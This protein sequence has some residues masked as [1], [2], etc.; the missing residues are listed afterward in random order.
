MDGDSAYISLWIPTIRPQDWL[1][2][3]HAH[4][5][6]WYSYMSLYHFKPM[7]NGTEGRQVSGQQNRVF[8]F[9][10]VCTVC[11][12]HTNENTCMFHVFNNGHIKFLVSFAQYH[13]ITH[14]LY[15]GWS[16]WHGNTPCFN[17]KLI[18]HWGF[19]NYKLVRF[20]SKIIEERQLARH[21]SFMMRVIS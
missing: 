4:L 2:V 5:W 9:C 12:N 14:D 1:I 18:L 16:D 3:T 21:E 19:V 20:L 15:V 10:R 8:G 6:Q 11:V 17:H 13:W 7:G